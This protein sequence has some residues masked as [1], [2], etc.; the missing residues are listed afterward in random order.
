MNN[1]QL[2]IGYVAGALALL[3]VVPYL[4]SILRGHAKPERATYAI[5]STINLLASISYIAVG[6]RTTVWVSL[7][8]TLSAILVFA[9]SFKFGMGG[10]NKF[11]LFCLVMAGA[12]II[13]WLLTKDPAL[14]LYYY[15]GIKLIGFLPT[16][17][18][19]YKWPKTEN[20]LSWIM[21]AAASLLNLLAITS[22][23]PQIALYPIYGAIGDTLL[24]Y[25][26]VRAIFKTRKSLKSK[27]AN[28]VEI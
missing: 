14:S 2:M 21:S 18:K 5:W 16:L 8:Y 1:I 7:A 12:G 19:A 11:D 23:T 4:L 26:L 10:L 13:V 6:A 25:V 22:W 15:I 17:K 20:A 24:T 9:L 27:L 28:L 3:Q